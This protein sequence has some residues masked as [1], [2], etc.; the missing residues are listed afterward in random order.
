MI[1]PTVLFENHIM[2][3]FPKRNISH[4]KNSFCPSEYISNENVDSIE[5]KTNN[6]LNWYPAYFPKILTIP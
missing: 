4:V 6:P 3:S 1:F 5:W 2:R